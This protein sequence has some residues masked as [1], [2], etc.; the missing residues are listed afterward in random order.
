MKVGERNKKTR[1]GL[2]LA[3]LLVF[4][5][6]TARAKTWFSGV[7]ISNDSRVLFRADYQNGIIEQNA[8]FL[9]N[10]ADWTMKQLTAFPEKLDLLENGRLILARN[11]FGWMKI[12]VTGGIPARASYADS[13]GIDDAVVSADGKWMLA[14]EPASPAYARLVLFNTGSGEKTLIAE[15]IEK[16]G[17]YFPAKWCPNSQVFIY[18]Q[19][20]NLY[21][22]SAGTEKPTDKR[23]RFIGQGGVSSIVWEERGDFF[24]IKEKNI[25]Q[26]RGSELFFRSLY[27]DFLS[28]GL[29]AG[30]LPFDFDPDFDEFYLAPD[31]KSL[32]ISKS[33]QT[34]FFYPFNVFFDSS[35]SSPN[36]L[37]YLRL[38]DFCSSLKVLWN[39]SNIITVIA[40]SR[41][42]TGKVITA[43]R[44]SKDASAFSPLASPDMDNAALSPDG[45]KA[46]LWGEKGAV[47][48]DYAAWREISVLSEAKTYSCFWLGY[49]DL[50][51]G[52]SSRIE[53]VHLNKNGE[54]RYLICLS[55]TEHFAFEKETNRILARNKGQWFASDGR[56]LWI[57]IENPA[58]R[59]ASLVSG[60]YRVYLEKQ[61]TGFYENLPMLRNIASVGTTPLLRDAQQPAYYNNRGETPIKIALCFDLYDDITGLAQ[62]LD[63]LDRFGVK[64]TF[65]LN[66]ECIRLYPEAV[67]RIVEA[68]HE[69][70]SLFFA[71]LNL[72]LP[73]YRISRDFIKRGLARNEDEFF[74][75]TGAELKL[76]WHPPFY[77]TSAEIIASASSAGYRTIAPD[78]DLSG[79]T[80]SAPSVIERIM[81]HI[82][83]KEKTEK[84]AG[85]Q[86]PHIIPIR[87]GAQPDDSR[88][89]NRVNVLLE[90]LT[91]LGYE[92]APVS[93]VIE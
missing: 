13:G 83:E 58:I 24:Y 77:Y 8:L 38:P 75:V 50:I 82:F 74:S 81:N 12:P 19:G 25:Y 57:P 33:G 4:P 88:I 6:V 73:E 20:G 15:Y 40:N 72:S 11:N 92:I 18:E 23:Y 61:S 5:C 49:D 27:R 64:A 63:A 21:Y 41:G 86:I 34:L 42:S 60:R 90:A 62:T 31:A 46:L 68:G 93:T 79:V 55:S 76:I 26:I 66:G 53:R 71:P 22:C 7:D 14:L 91:D 78:I 2:L 52:D 89:Y 69:A 35:A 85:K 17:R 48:Y 87:L 56:L 43:Y 30:T 65:F 37:P 70:A 67:K 36:A 39:E 44:L 29:I 80:D 10:L 59:P 51:M 1:A 84:K 32:L 54:E 3:V 28:V 47:L 45:N 9:S 16:N